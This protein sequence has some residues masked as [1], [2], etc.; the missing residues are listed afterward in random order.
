V[1]E[2][3]GGPVARDEV[4]NLGYEYLISE[5]KYEIKSNI[6]HIGKINLGTFYHRALLYKV[7]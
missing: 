4:A 2:R 6:I 5:T 3:L 1:A 7:S